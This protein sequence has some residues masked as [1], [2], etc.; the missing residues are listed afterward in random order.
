[1]VNSLTRAPFGQRRELEPNAIDNRGAIEVIPSREQVP[2]LRGRIVKDF[3]TPWDLK[4]YEQPRP[5]LLVTGWGNNWASMGLASVLDMCIKMPSGRVILPQALGRW[6]SLVQYVASIEARQ[7]A[8]WWHFA[9]MYLTVDQYYV[10]QGQ[11][12]RQSGWHVDGIQGP[13]HLQKMT[14]CHQYVM[15]S[16]QPTEFAVQPF[17]VSGVDLRKSN[18][19]H[20]LS[21]QVLQQSVIQIP[22]NVLT[23]MNAYS[24]HRSPVAENN[25]FRTFVRIEVSHKRF[26]RK[27][28][29]PN[30][31]LPNLDWDWQPRPIPDD[32]Y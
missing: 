17:Y 21:R 27:G 18:L 22:P 7:N 28:N 4:Q 1:M 30:P 6:F 10:P 5:P 12:Q 15:C 16:R 9:Y 23:L 29:T 32:L 13:R 24:V 11:S 3:G 20:A 8:P 25:T 2:T 14:V 26:D 19:N 31:A